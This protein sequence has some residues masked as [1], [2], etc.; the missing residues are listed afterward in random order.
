MLCPRCAKM[1]EL[2]C[3]GCMR[4]VP[5]STDASEE[6]CAHCLQVAISVGASMC[7][8]I[9]KVMGTPAAAAKEIAS[10]R[11]R[12]ASLAAQFSLPERVIAFVPPV[13]PDWTR[14]AASKRVLQRSRFDEVM[15]SHA[16]VRR[17][18]ESATRSTVNFETR[19]ENACSAADAAREVLTAWDGLLVDVRDQGRLEETLVAYSDSIRSAKALL[20]RLK[21]RDL[22]RALDLDAA[23]T[24]AMSAYKIAQK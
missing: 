19:I 7:A 16:Q 10:L 9:L 23:R 20:E 5:R 8:Q 1:N 13:A 22:S 11:T 17:E 15:V 24:A 6:V 3:G 14:V 18:V 12:F 2:Y 21:E 4:S